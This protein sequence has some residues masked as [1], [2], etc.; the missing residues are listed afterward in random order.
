MLTLP[1]SL[2]WVSL[3]RNYIFI[4]WFFIYI[5]LYF[6]FSILFVGWGSVC[7]A[8][9]NHV[10]AHPSCCRLWTQLL[11]CLQNQK[12]AIMSRMKKTLVILIL[13]LL[14]SAT[15]WPHHTC[16]SHDFANPFH[17]KYCPT[18]GIM[19]SKLPWHHCELFCLET[20]NCQSVNYNLT[21]SICTYFTAT[22]PRA[23]SHPGM[24]FV[25]FTGRQSAECI[26]WIPKRNGHPKGDDRSMTEDNH[27]FAARM[28]KKGNDI[29]GYQLHEICYSRDEEGKLKSTHGYPC[30]YLRIRDG[31][32]VFYMKYEL[33]TPL[34]PNAM[35][36]GYTAGGLPVYIGIKEGG[37][38]PKSY[39]P[40][41]NR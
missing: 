32:T 10:S 15:A 29:L 24:A 41:V 13:S 9:K 1:S 26:E 38:T 12:R 2:F 27:R 14:C 22:C 25:V 16:E 37:V 17:G 18:E 39:I 31:C 36:G 40:G 35:I 19:I 30:Q 34:P 5:Y 4:L 7:Y 23:M 20:P 33:G 6:P 8:T 11:H 28:Q 21:D 3:W